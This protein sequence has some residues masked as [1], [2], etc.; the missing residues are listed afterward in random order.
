MNPAA[1]KSYLSGIEQALRTGNATEHTHRPALKTLIEQIATGI[2]ATN[3]PKRIKCGAPDYIVTRNTIPLGYIE[4]K[5]VGVPLDGV[6]SGEQLKRYRES[7]ANL[8]LTDYLEFRWYVAGEHRLTVKLAKADKTG[9]LKLLPDATEQLNRLL[10]SFL[11]ADI[12]VINNPRDLAIRMAAMARLIRSII[13]KTFADEG[14][15]GSLHQQMQAFQKV[16]LNDMTP[17][18]FGDMYAQTICYGL[19]A[20]RCNAPSAERFTRAHA[21]Y[22]LPKTNPFLRKMFGHVAGPELDDRIVWAVDDLAELLAKS[23]IGAILKDFGR[24]TRQEDPI[25][26]FYETFLGHYD[27]KMRE[28]RGVYYTPEPVVSYIV[29]SVDR[30]LKSDFKLSNGL[31]DASKIKIKRPVRVKKTGKTEF[32]TVETHKVQILD[33]ATGTGTFLYNVIEQIRVTF[34]GNAGMWPGYVAEHLL[35]RIYG[36][37]LLMAP[38]AVAHMKLGLQLKASGY[39]FEADER[40]RVY[41]TNTLEEAHEMTGLPLFTQWLAEEANSAASVKR[42]T[43]IMVVLGNPPYSG[44]SANTG[45]WI[46]GLLRGNDRATNQKTGNYFEVDGVP[47]G[48]RNPKWLNDDYVKFIRFAQWRIEQTGYG[49]LA[50]VTNHGYLDNPTFRGM[51]QSLMQSFD[52]IYLLDLHGNSKK[53]E[54]APDGGKDENVFDIQQGVAIGIFVK[55][56]RASD[57]PATV[58]HADL[59]GERE[60][61]YRWLAEC[62]LKSTTWR[63]LQPQ[64]PFY[65][66]VPQDETL[67]VEFEQGWKITDI[68]PVNS[69][70]IV[71]ARDALTIH[72]NRDDAW[73]TVKDFAALP[74]EEAREKYALGKDAQDWKV[75][76]AQADLRAS[77]PDKANLAPILYRPF[78]VRHTYYTGKPSGFLCRPRNDVMRHM[79]AGENLALIS[80]R[81]NKSDTPDHFFCS[82]FISEAKTGEATTQSALFPLYL[83]PKSDLFE[84]GNDSC[85]PNLSPAFL[86]ALIDQLGAAPTPVDCFHY[87][88]AVFHSPTYRSRYAEFLKIDFPRLPLTS[89]A[90]LFRSLCALGQQLVGLHLMETAAPAICRYPIAGDNKVETVRYADGRVYINAVQYFEGVPDTVWDFHIGGYQVAHKWLKDRKGRQLSYD[91]LTHYQQVMAALAETLRLQ[92]AIDQA[93]TQWPIQ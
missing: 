65:L 40:L 8:I 49:V 87:A 82:R 70:G 43:P 12:P 1:L 79:L 16:L 38:Y 24:H 42:D 36:F 58:R 62:D 66:F 25:V 61:K 17:E 88:Y 85:T 60:G 67:R 4:A 22:D 9:K 19:F 56:E 14:D 2:T 6:E 68:M 55:L 10:D 52:D 33:P 63:T 7:L 89:D 5:D 27:A 78:D 84:K 21:A 3:E 93:I 41:L 77:G 30:L 83:Y 45:E 73:Q 20:A 11:N 18:Q 34:S 72:W 28:A 50:F 44:H 15:E 74:P 92:A 37:E 80:A 71:T 81:S 54:K 86:A 53:K 69:V 57:K 59:F 32:V 26:H 76:L 46:A 23:D 48:E 35:P 13:S 39:D 29:R 64:A 51:R 31:A 90:R 75:P 47:L 91:D